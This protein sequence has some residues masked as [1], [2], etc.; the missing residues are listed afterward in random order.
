MGDKPSKKQIARAD[1]VRAFKEWRGGLA[2]PTDRRCIPVRLTDVPVDVRLGAARQVSANE[3]DHGEKLALLHAALF[4]S[5][6][7]YFV[8]A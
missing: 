5:D 3:L 8:A 2:V 7:V 4:P 1:E 6:T